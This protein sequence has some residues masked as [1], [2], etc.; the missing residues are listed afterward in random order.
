[1]S[2]PSEVEKLW[3]EAWQ[4][5][6]GRA[7]HEVKGALNGVSLNLEVVRSRTERG[8][9]DAAS[10]HKFAAAA[11]SEMELL[12]S[13]NEAL[14]FLGRPH[15]PGGA[16]VDIGATLRQLAVLLVPAA[17]ADGRVLEVDIAERQAFTK[18]R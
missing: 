14:L 13:F 18:A 7:A 5:V 2:R 10:L 6:V 15:R 16:G 8:A 1:M 17:R 11:S 4:E 12:T 9:S 3:L